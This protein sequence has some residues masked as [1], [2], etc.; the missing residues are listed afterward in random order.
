MAVNGQQG[1][2]IV[3]DLNPGQ[4][5]HGV[6]VSYMVRFGGGSA[7]PADGMS[8]VWAPDLAD[9]PF[10]ED[11]AG[12]GLVVTFDIFDNAG[13]EAPAIDVS[14]GGVLLAT[15][16]VPISFLRTGDA[17][18]PV[19]IRVENDGTLD[20]VYNGQ[21]IYHNLQLP[22]FAGFTGGRFGWGARTGGLNE[23]QWVDDIQIST[24]TTSAPRLTISHTG[25]NVTVSWTAGQLQSAPS[26]NGPWA[27]ETGATSPMTFNNTTGMRFFRTISP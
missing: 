12:S 5:V 6:T 19:I 14:F 2:F 1:A 13:G 8:F 17:F 7:V 10:G 21:V 11:G 9:G 16:K 23:N 24:S 20:V 22:G 18:V 25:N 4:T 27:T 3:N 26:I 15:T